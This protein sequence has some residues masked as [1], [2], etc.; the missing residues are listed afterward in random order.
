MP[1]VGSQG[2]SLTNALAESI[3]GLYKTELIRRHG[4]WSSVGEVERATVAWVAWWNNRRLHGSLGYP[5]SSRVRGHSC[6]Q[7]A[8]GGG[9]SSPPTTRQTTPQPANRRLSFP[10]RG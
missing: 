6:R 4:R 1:S 8:R 3:N 2:D 10:R 9:L 7:P 5:A